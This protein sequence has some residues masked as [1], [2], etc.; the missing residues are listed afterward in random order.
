MKKM[1]ALGLLALACLLQWAVPATLAVQSEMTLR[2]GARY[3]FR[4]APVDPADAF[5]GRYV[6]LNFEGLRVTVPPASG[7]QSGDRAYVPLT[8]GG[9]R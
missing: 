7:L 4:T 3:Y 9:D 2:S 5:R 8:T 6:A 1:L